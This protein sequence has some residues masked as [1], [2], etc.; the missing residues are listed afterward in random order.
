MAGKNAA[1]EVL[2]ATEPRSGTEMTDQELFR[3][4]QFLQFDDGDEENLKSINELAR[5]YA[6]SVIDDFYEHLLS[7]EDTATFF[8]D[9]ATLEHV[10][11]AQQQYFLRLTQGNYDLAYAKDRLRIGA[12]H[13]RVGLPVKAYLGMYN[14]Y[15]R[16]VA[17]RLAEAYA[18]DP[19][20]SWTAF[21]SLMKLTFLDIGLAIDTYID[22]SEQTIR[23]QREAIQELPTPVLPFR[24]GMLLVPV[25]GLI[26]GE[27]AR[28]LTEQLLM[29]IRNNRAKA[30]VIDVTGVQ[31]VDS[32]VANHIVQT[33]EAARLM[34]ATAIIAGVSPEIA[35]TMV[36]LGIDLGRM[37]TVGDLQSGIEEADKLAGYSLMRMRDRGGPS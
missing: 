14:F 8:S 24:D 36:T 12:V 7:F 16:A 18:S 34:G 3:R 10:K 26:S 37:M 21:L 11:N 1:G 22:S 30:V 6:Q 19:Q 2:S 4:K 13:E 33:V 28:Q 17:N 23:E 25:I 29:A 5:R 15:L 27:R 9:P 32:R 20:K 31:A 35:Q